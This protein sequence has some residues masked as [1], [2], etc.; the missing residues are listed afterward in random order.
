MVAVKLS[1]QVF[2]KVVIIN[3]HCNT[4]VRSNS[5]QSGVTVSGQVYQYQVLI[6]SVSGQLNTE[7]QHH[8]SDNHPVM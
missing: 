4:G 1:S 6:M 7:P 2:V 5:I 3:R 8:M